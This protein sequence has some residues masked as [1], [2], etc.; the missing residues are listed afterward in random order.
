MRSIN[1]HHPARRK[2][3]PLL[4]QIRDE[5]LAGVLNRGVAGRDVD[6]EVGGAF[7]E[8]LALVF[9]AILVRL[10]DAEEDHLR[11]V[12]ARIVVGDLVFFRFC[13]G[14]LAHDWHDGVL[15]HE[16]Q[17][18]ADGVALLDQGLQFFA[19]E[20]GG[21]GVREGARE[22][23]AVFAQEAHAVEWVAGEVVGDFLA[24]LA[25]E[26][27]VDTGEGGLRVVGLFG[28][29]LVCGG[30]MRGNGSEIE[31]EGLCDY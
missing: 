13:V 1:I 25:R 8:V 6:G 22:E 31:Q 14:I 3:H 10:V 12:D 5:L 4:R 20:E 21:G 30:W 17:L 26:H 29:C 19:D 18:V 11:D 2:R 9:H 23:L 24:E 15:A 7:V 27:R 28:H 16:L